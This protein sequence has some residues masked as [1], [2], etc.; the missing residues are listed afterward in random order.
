MDPATV[1][2]INTDFATVLTFVHGLE[3][4]QTY[5]LRLLLNHLKSNFLF[6]LLVCE[7]NNK[8]MIWTLQ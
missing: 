8:L 3:L 6:N 4:L 1:N 2:K 7:E 5:G